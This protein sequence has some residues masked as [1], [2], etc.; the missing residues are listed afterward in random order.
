M[1]KLYIYSH[2]ISLKS[3]NCLI[4]YN[5]FNNIYRFDLMMV[6]QFLG[7]YYYTQLMYV[8][9][10]TFKIYLMKIIYNLIMNK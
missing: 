7:E 9:I 10:I 2:N 3:V 8:S 5:T 4:Q 1:K 6:I